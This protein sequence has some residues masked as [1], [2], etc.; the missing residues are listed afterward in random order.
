VTWDDEEKIIATGT[1]TLGLSTE[2]GGIESFAFSGN[3]I[4]VL[5][6]TKLRLNVVCRSYGKDYP[7][8]FNEVSLALNGEDLLDIDPSIDGPVRAGGGSQSLS[9]WFYDSMHIN[10]INIDF[11]ALDDVVCEWSF[12]NFGY[13]ESF[14]F[15]LDWLNP[16]DTGMEPMMYY[17]SN[18]EDGE[19][20]DGS[21]ESIS[22]TPI[23]TWT[24]ASGSLGSIV[25]VA[26]FGPY[27]TGTTMNYYKDD[28]S[29]DLFDTGDYMSFG[30][31]GVMVEW[32]PDTP[33]DEYGS[34]WVDMTSYILG[35]DQ[36]NLG[37]T[38]EEFPD[39]PLEVTVD[40]QD[41]IAILYLPM[42]FVHVP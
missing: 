27:I 17:D 39:N 35:P 13:I 36:P 2:F 42:I 20:I 8:Y 31:S 1:Y 33:K 34:L 22:I 26:D 7:F 40:R 11:N 14:R 19:P 38:Y 29:E 4:D 25:R 28:D 10:I 32:P 15:S 9:N 24:Q 3:D 41:F 30:D 37:E 5:D 12:N 21:P 6:R 16:T 18:T 23:N